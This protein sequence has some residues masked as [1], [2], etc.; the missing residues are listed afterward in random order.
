MTTAEQVID[1]DW[2]LISPRSARKNPSPTVADH[3]RPRKALIRLRKTPPR[4]GLSTPCSAAVLSS[5]AGSGLPTALPSSS[6]RASS[7]G[8]GG[9]LCSGTSID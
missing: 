1:E 6:K 7:S 5:A 3:P 8:G 4:F 9:W 2:R